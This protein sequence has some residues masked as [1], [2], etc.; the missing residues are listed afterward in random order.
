MWS[1]RELYR[2]LEGLEGATSKFGQSRNPAEE[3]EE[4]RSSKAIEE[5]AALHTH[6]QELF[7][8]V[9]DHEWGKDPELDYRAQIW[10][11]LTH[12]ILIYKREDVMF[13]ADL[14]MRVAMKV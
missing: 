9:A 1:T 11:A 2:W 14:S 3:D 4:R 13:W 12:S 10:L 7:D 6:T 8:K 5:L